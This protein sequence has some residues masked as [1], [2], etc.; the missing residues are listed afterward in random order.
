MRHHSLAIAFFLAFLVSACAPSTSVPAV[1]T[2][3]AQD[4]AL[5]TT[6]THP[7]HATFSAL[8]LTVTE[9]E[10]FIYSGSDKDQFIVATNQFYLRYPGFCPL[11]TAFFQG[12]SGSTFMTLAGR[13]GSD[14][15]GFIYDMSRRPA[16][17]YIYFSATSIHALP[18]TRCLTASP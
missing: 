15:R 18:A 5:F 17:R 6:L 9:Y 14:I 7:L 10:T 1:A 13:G 8:G 3:G 11:E 12:E 16:L 4:E 2:A